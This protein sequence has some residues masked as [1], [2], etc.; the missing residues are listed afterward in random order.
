M[1]FLSVLWTMASTRP[2][3]QAAVTKPDKA[4]DCRIHH[5]Q[6]AQLLSPIATLRPLQPSWDFRSYNDSRQSVTAPLVLL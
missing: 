6:G 3:R 5:T 2:L 4:A 1:K